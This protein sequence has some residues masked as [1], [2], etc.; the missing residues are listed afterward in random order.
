[1]TGD[2]VV[3]PDLATDILKGLLL[4]DSPGRM[5]GSWR[6]TTAA[7]TD[8]L[9][10]QCTEPDLRYFARNTHDGT[11]D[12]SSPQTAHATG[13]SDRLYR[14]SMNITRSPATPPQGRSPHVTTELLS[15]AARAIVPLVEEYRKPGMLLS[16]Q[17]QERVIRVLEV[18]VVRPLVDGLVA[19]IDLLKEDV[20]EADAKVTSLEQERDSAARNLAQR[21]REVELIIDGKANGPNAPSSDLM[22]RLRAHV[23]GLCDEIEKLQ[24]ELLAEQMREK[25]PDPA[26]WDQ[27]ERLKREVAEKEAS[28]DHSNT[29]IAHLEASLAKAQEPQPSAESRPDVDHLVNMLRESHNSLIAANKEATDALEHERAKHRAELEQLKW[30]YAELKRTADLLIS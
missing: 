30:N 18:M 27:T 25:V 7:V 2:T 5:S 20:T 21:D 8:E 13:P 1:M 29:R 23:S 3:L 24:Q 28:L 19:T 22:C 16:F 17:F 15:E 12:N 10:S 4:D 14:S 26:L 6:H 9:S 11:P